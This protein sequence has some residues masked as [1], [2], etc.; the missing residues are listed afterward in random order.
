[1][2]I[3]PLK[4][5]GIFVGAV[6]IYIYVYMSHPFSIYLLFII[7]YIFIRWLNFWLIRFPFISVTHSDKKYSGKIVFSKRKIKFKYIIHLFV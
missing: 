5:L 3:D 2:S 6:Y 4:M 1:M 7:I